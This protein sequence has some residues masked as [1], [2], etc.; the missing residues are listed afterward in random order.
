MEILVLQMLSAEFH[1]TDHYAIVP[2]AGVEIL[3]LNVT[4]VSLKKFLV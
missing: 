2:A 1:I 4:N 3:K